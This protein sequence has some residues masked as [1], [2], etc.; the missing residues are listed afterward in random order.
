MPRGKHDSTPLSRRMHKA[1]GWPLPRENPTCKRCRDAGWFI[2]P[3]HGTTAEGA[4]RCDC[5]AG[6][7]APKGLPRWQVPKPRPEV[8]QPKW[9]ADRAAGGDEDES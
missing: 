7:T 4:W 8:E 2:I 1:E 6:E 9:G 3:A 5:A